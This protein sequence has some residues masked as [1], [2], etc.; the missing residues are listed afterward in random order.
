MFLHGGTDIKVNAGP[1]DDSV[2]EKI[3]QSGEDQ[4][5]GNGFT[6]SSSLGDP[7]DKDSHKRCP[8]HPPCPVEDGPGADPVTFKSWGGKKAHGNEM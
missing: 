2:P 8:T 7:G 3:S 6:D 5:G 4:G 1:T